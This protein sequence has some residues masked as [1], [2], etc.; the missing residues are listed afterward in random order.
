MLL[1]VGDHWGGEVGENGKRGSGM[2]RQ[3]AGAKGEEGGKRKTEPE[4]EEVDVR[5]TS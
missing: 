2:R 1:L 4:S 3:T 5:L